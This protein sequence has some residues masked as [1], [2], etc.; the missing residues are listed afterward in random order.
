MAGSKF[1]GTAVKVMAATTL[2]AGLLVITGC[3][4]KLVGHAGESTINVYSNKDDFDKLMSMKSRG[5]AEGIVGGL[6]E[7]FMATKVPENTQV[8]ILSSDSEGDEVQVLQGPHAG[9][10]GY[11]AKDNVD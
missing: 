5:G 4:H 3:N 11:V 6:G 8:K 9:L 2:L 1:Q 7:S 10:K